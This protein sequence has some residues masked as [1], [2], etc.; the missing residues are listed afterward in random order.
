MTG[1]LRKCEQEIEKAVFEIAKKYGYEQLAVTGTIDPK[2]YKSH[3]TCWGCK[4]ETGIE[5]MSIL[6]YD[7]KEK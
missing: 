3:R 7:G 2:Y 4:H 6:F 1:K 5:G